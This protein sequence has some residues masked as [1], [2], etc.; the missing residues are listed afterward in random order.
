MRERRSSSEI[1]SRYGLT[2]FQVSG[3]GESLGEYGATFI[4]HASVCSLPRYHGTHTHAVLVSPPSWP[5]LPPLFSFFVRRK[6]KDKV[7]CQ[8]PSQPKS[9]RRRE[10]IR[11]AVVVSERRRGRGGDLS[12]NRPYATQD[13]RQRCF[14]FFLHWV[15]FQRSTT[16]KNRRMVDKDDRNGRRKKVRSTRGGG[17]E[18]F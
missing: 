16:T 5:R 8:Q 7:Q 11:S 14:S 3:S 10:Q 1:G 4:F 15:L 12:I 13:Q 17:G 9:Q 2:F 18:P 6:K